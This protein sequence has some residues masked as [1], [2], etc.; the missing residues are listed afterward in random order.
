MKQ[1]CLSCQLIV[2]IYVMCIEGCLVWRFGCCIG[3]ISWLADWFGWV[4][5]NGVALALA[6]AW[7][8]ALTLAVAF[9]LAP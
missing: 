4:G 6:W 8:L 5:W 1:Y 3:L 7:A 2:R 9:A